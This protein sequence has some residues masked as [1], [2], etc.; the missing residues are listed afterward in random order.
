MTSKSQVGPMPA[1]LP[2]LHAPRAPAC[3]RDCRLPLPL[4]FRWRGHAAPTPLPPTRPTWTSL[5]TGL[6]ACT[7]TARRSWSTSSSRVGWGGVGGASPVLYGSASQPTNQAHRPVTCQSG[8][9]RSQRPCCTPHPPPCV[10]GVHPLCRP[11]AE[12]PLLR[13]QAVWVGALWRAGLKSNPKPAHCHCCPRR[14]AAPRR[15]AALNRD[16]R[17]QRL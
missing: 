9:G 17:V 3:L 15:A 8:P 7:A 2:H 1:L 12:L 6:W 4:A 10:H 14:C 13:P 11:R 16:C 5:A